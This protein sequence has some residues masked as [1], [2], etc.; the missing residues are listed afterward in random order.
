[1]NKR[2]DLARKGEYLVKE[3]LEDLYEVA[4]PKI[5]RLI[6]K[7]LSVKE[8]AALCWH[9]TFVTPRKVLAVVENPERVRQVVLLGLDGRRVTFKVGSPVK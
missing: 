2:K 6:L 5:L 9:A 1:M 3:C 7:H 4:S 8:Q